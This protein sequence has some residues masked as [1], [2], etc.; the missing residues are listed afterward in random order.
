[1]DHARRHVMDT[2]YYV[3]CVFTYTCT[4][5]RFVCDCELFRAFR[6]PKTYTGCP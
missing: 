5:S 6:T 1:M 4:S 3:L 2:L